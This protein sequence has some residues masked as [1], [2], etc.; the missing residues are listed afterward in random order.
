M[1]E[2]SV[3]GQAP[4]ATIAWQGES[5]ELSGNAFAAFHRPIE[6]IEILRNGEV[7]ASY[8][9]QNDSG[10]LAFELEIRESAWIAARALA[11]SETGEPVLQAHTNPIYF[12]REGR[13]VRVEAA[14]AALRE[15]WRRE[16]EYYRSGELVFADE[17]QRR[18]FLSRVEETSRLLER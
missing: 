18:E 5:L 4:G 8:D 3:N 11:R 10:S 15:R 13:P 12:H 6:R 9:G 7:A 16:T 14:R 1:L 17:A 2:L